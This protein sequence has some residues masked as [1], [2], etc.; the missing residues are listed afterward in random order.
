MGSAAA[1]ED[2]KTAW[3]DQRRRYRELLQSKCSSFWCDTVE[4][5]RASPSKLWKSID[6]LL[7]RRKLPTSSEISVD[8]FNR[9]FADKVSTVRV[10]TADAPELSYTSV[11][12]GVSMPAFSAMSV[13]DVMTAIAKLPDKS[14]AAD[15]LPLPLVK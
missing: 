12:C 5:N 9:F 1:A 7:G 10:K 3:Y 15:P 14:S 6:Q 4:A 2:A 11:R 8:D 13:A